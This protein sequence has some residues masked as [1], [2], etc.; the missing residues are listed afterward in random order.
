MD[1]LI[2]QE[3]KMSYKAKR[4]LDEYD[5][6]H[7]FDVL[8]YEAA[9]LEFKE[10]IENFEDIHVRLKR[11]LGE[12]AYLKQY[13]EFFERLKPLTDWVVKAKRDLMVRKRDLEKSKEEEKD[14]ERQKELSMKEM[15]GKQRE[16]ELEFQ[17]K[18]DRE[19]MK[20]QVK[21]LGKRIDSD[22]KSIENEGSEFLED[23]SR[24]IENVRQLIKE[25]TNVFAEVETVFGADF[26]GNFLTTMKIRMAG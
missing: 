2:D 13:P 14:A 12:D 1:D 15:E 8:E 20:N 16:V 11:G 22:L 7:M 21:H 24:N 10:A 9:I 25:F 17:V 3:T 26:E 23:L 6:E 19:R 18:R 5:L 4:L